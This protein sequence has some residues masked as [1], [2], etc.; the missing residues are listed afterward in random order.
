MNIYSDF[1]HYK[2]A[3]ANFLIEKF[4]Y[5]EIEAQYVTDGYRD[6]MLRIGLFDNPGDWAT[7]LDSALKYHITPD[8]WRLTLTD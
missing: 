5:S 4:N 6:I 1:E 2:Q 8:M 3:V 7:H